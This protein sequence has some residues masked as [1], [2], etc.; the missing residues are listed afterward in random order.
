VY[1]RRLGLPASTLT[2]SLLGLALI[3]SACS[4]TQRPGGSGGGGGGGNKDAQVSTDTGSGGGDAGS[5]PQ[6]DGG[7]TTPDGGSTTFD[8]SGPNDTGSTSTPDSGV[9]PRPDAGSAPF[10]GGVL[11]GDSFNPQQA[12]AQY[13]AAA[14]AF[15]TRCQPVFY[16]FN[17]S[18]EQQC[19]SELTAQLLSTFNAYAPLVQAGRSAYSA[20]GLTQCIQAYQQASCT[21]WVSPT[22]CDALFRGNRPEGAPCGASIECGA[23]SFCAAGLGQCGSC[24][25]Y[26]AVGDACANAQG[27]ATGLCPP[28]SDCYQVGQ[29]DFACVSEDVAVGQPCNTADTGICRGANDCIGPEGMAG[30]CTAP[31]TRVGASC[32]NDGA[33]G[34]LCNIYQN[35]TCTMNNTCAT[36]TWVGTGSQCGMAA[37]TNGCSS[38]N[39]CGEMADGA[40]ANTCIALPGPGAACATTRGLCATG[41]FCDAQGTCRAE[42]G[43]GQSCTPDQ[44]CAGDNFCINSSC[45]ALFFNAACN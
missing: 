32:A 43:V 29:T 14:C 8:A 37:P 19:V 40:Q 45:G 25:R 30:T 1:M 36:V 41:S 44:E 2:P 12:A 5:N 28:G 9:T 26:L 35:L 42:V 15:Q 17:G 23:G 10:D 6:T 24:L 11:T 13:A 18:N 38:G 34:P 31:A 33:S 3:V 4:D 22:A 27:Q 20:A 16:S 39:R 7:V 21:D